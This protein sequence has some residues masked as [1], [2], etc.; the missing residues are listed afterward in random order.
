MVGFAMVLVVAGGFGWLWHE[1][2]AVVT[3]P[4]PMEVHIPS[5]ASS[6]TIASLLESRGVIRSAL[7]FRLVSRLRGEAGKL[8]SGVYRFAEPADM[9]SILDRLVRGDVVHYS[10]TI[11]EGLRND[12]VLKLLA[13]ETGT[14]VSVWERALVELLP[15][16]EEGRLLPETYDYIL[17]L[18]P[19]KILAAMISAQER[20][21]SALAPP[22]AWE[23]LRIMAS[24]IEKETAVDAERPLIAAVIHNRL[25]KNM[26]LQM[27]P[28]VIYGIW[29]TRGSFSGDIRYRDLRADTPWNTYVHK[30]LPPTPIC[31]PGRASLRAAAQ[32]AD[33][34]YLY[35][36]ADGTGR[37]V[38]SASL[39]EHQKHVKQ[40]LRL[41]KQKDTSSNDAGG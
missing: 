14:D 37:H 20:E 18:Q 10:L 17:P 36:V 21:L 15:G 31:N 23:R 12:E 2:T 9:K 33:V 32:P 25:H 29:R 6:A 40:W 24:I 39:A 34:D 28:T 38:F 41:E 7:V 4:Q 19:K 11:P 13:G 16:G 27:D 26:P 3:P 35:F 8:K 22:E 1:L 5:G 30:G